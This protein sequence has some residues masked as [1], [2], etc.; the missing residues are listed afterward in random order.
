MQSGLAP[1]LRGY[2]ASINGGIAE[3]SFTKLKSSR[4]KSDS[5]TATA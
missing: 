5:W 1:D 4:P 2:A 3:I